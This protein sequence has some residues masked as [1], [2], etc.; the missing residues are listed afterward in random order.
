MVDYEQKERDI[1]NKI[2]EIEGKPDMWA[3]DK[4]CKERIALCEELIR[5]RQEQKENEDSA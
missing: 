1:M 2:I 3:N 5:L 4:L